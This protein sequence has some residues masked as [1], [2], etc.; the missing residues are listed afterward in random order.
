MLSLSKHESS[1]YGLP[2][3]TTPF[4]KLGVRKSVKLLMLSLSKHEHPKATL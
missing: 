1:E 2:L 4:N 3:N